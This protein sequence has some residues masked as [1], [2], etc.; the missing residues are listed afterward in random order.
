MRWLGAGLMA[1]PQYPRYRLN[2]LASLSSVA[3]A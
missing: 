2:L 3:T 1:T